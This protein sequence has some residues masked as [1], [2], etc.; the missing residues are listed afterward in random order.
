MTVSGRNAWTM[1]ILLC[2]A[3][4]L[5]LWAV[6]YSGSLD[7]Y[8]YDAEG[9]LLY[10]DE[11]G[12]ERE[13]EGRGWQFATGGD[14]WALPSGD[15]N[16]PPGY[17]L[18][19]ATVYRLF[20]RHLEIL[21]GLN[22]VLGAVTVALSFSLAERFWGRAAGWLAALAVAL[23]PLQLYWSSRVM[24][25]T[26]GTTLALAVVTMAVAVEWTPERRWTALLGGVLAGLGVVVR[27]NLLVVP[28][29]VAIWWLARRPLAGIR[30][31]I[32]PVSLFTAGCALVVLPVAVLAAQHR[33]GTSGSQWD[34][35]VGLESMTV[36]SLV[37]VRIQEEAARR[38][39]S[40]EPGEAAAVRAAAIDEARRTPQWR[41]LATVWGARA[42]AFW[43]FLPS[44]RPPIERAAYGIASGLMTV[45]GLLGLVLAVR[46]GGGSRR[47]AL[48]VV[49][50]ALGF[51]A[52]HCLL[53]SR[54]RY[55]L[56]LHPL[57]WLVAV[58]PLSARYLPG[59]R[60]ER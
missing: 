36:G 18:L 17:P 25:E 27:N 14:L 59:W 51:T 39:T 54:P 42:G 50:L 38:G 49:L 44:G 24:T 1:A 16:G 40:L 29:A 3:V 19:V 21:L 47:F 52:L 22:A 20:G 2:G 30:E 23:D 31:R 9:L 46:A 34:Q 45:G 10:G 43:Q 60:L 5:R 32:L 58:G 33:P 11:R 28:L 26:L 6:H 56:P 57:L 37:D 12:D 35:L 7:R 15:G 4:V 48:L 55:R 41:I 13:Y 8:H 53:V